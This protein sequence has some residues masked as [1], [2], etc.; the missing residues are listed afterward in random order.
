MTKKHKYERHRSA[1]PGEAYVHVS[2]ESGLEIYVYPKKHS[3][4]HVLLTVEY[5]AGDRAFRPCPGAPTVV[6]PDGTAHFLEHKMF[7]NEDGGDAFED[8]AALGADAN[9]FTSSTYTEYCFTATEHVYRALGILLRMVREPHFS[10]GSVARE[11]E[12]IA[13]E[14]RMEEDDPWQALY[15]GTMRALYH[16]HPLR[17][18]VAGTVDS[19]AQIGP[20]QLRACFDT[21]YNLRNMTLFV[22]GDVSPSAI[23]RTADR[24]LA[25][26]PPFTAERIR[27]AEP[28]TVAARRFYREMEVAQ[29]LFTIALK[30][31]HISPDP[32]VRLRRQCVYD[33]L[34][35]VLLSSSSPLRTALY[36]EGLIG[37]QLS[38]GFSHCSEYSYNEITGESDDPE[39]VYTR[40]M[41]HVGRLKKTG[42][43]PDAFERCR[44]AVYAASVRS[45]EDTVETAQTLAD[46]V[47]DGEEMFDEP[48]AVLS[49]TREELD[50]ALGTVFREEAAV[51][52]VVAPPRR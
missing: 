44:R 27:P 23:V 4:A 16:E 13:E 29:P 15:A 3:A 7:E 41:E 1:F 2:H 43:P 46:F 31:R 12:I 33:I 52:G 19:V 47:L 10:E 37:P 36:E 45:F 17:I 42:I 9:A 48:R 28:E 24:C 11:R 39:A 25:P 49:V 32:A 30:D 20:E 35:A 38:Y 5:G 14:I 8:F 6:V 34:N 40:L 22:C 18:P 21:F 51:M 50:E 26:A